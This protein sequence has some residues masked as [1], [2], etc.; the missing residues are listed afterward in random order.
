MADIDPEQLKRTLEDVL[1]STTSNSAPPSG[2]TPGI[3]DTASVTNLLGSIVTVLNQILQKIGGNAA[4]IPNLNV[5]DLTTIPIALMGLKDA[6]TAAAGAIQGLASKVPLIGG[7]LGK[8]VTNF[9]QVLDENF[10]AGQQGIGQGNYFEALG[11]AQQAGFNNLA[12]QLKYLN[13]N[14]NNGVRVIGKTADESNQR[15][16][17]LQT[18]TINTAQG[19][20]LINNG[21]I[22]ARQ[23]AEIAGLTAAS[24]RELMKSDASRQALAED[25]AKLASQMQ[26]TADITGV[27]I[28]EQIKTLQEIK[29]TSYQQLAEQVL[30]NDL[31]RQGLTATQRQFGSQGKD[32]QTLI[33]TIYAG[34]RLTRDQQRLLTQAT[35][36]RGGELIALV[37]EARRTSGLADTDPAKIAARQALDTFMAGMAKY[38]SSPEFA[39]R[40]LQTSDPALRSTLERIYADNKERGAI[41]AK[42]RESGLTAEEARK[43][44]YEGQGLARQ[45]GERQEGDLGQAPIKNYAQEFFKGFYE[46]SEGARKNVGALAGELGNLTNVLERTKNASAAIRGTGELIGGPAGRTQEE[47][48]D[49]AKETV[50]NIAGTLLGTK[51]AEAKPTETPITRD[52]LGRPVFNTPEVSIQNPSNVVINS[53]PTTKPET[54]AATPATPAPTGPDTRLRARGTLG[55]TGF[56]TELTDG[57]RY[58]HKGETTATPEQ[59][60]NLMQNSKTN[61]I[62]E[63]LSGLKSSTEG[64]TADTTGIN[65]NSIFEKF[66][67]TISSVLSTAGKIPEKTVEPVETRSTLTV[68]D[69]QKLVPKTEAPSIPSIEDIQKLVPKV[70]MP[71]LPSIEDIQ[72][73]I[74]KVE[75]KDDIKQDMP[76]KINE[77]ISNFKESFSNFKPEINLANLSQ[78]KDFAIPNITSEFSDF[79]KAPEFEMPKEPT[80]EKEETSEMFEPVDSVS[81]KDL[82]EALIQLNTGVRQ[83]VAKS[84]ESV[85]LT[86]RHLDATKKLSGNRFA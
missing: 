74:P 55:E 59:L 20:S 29:N 65:L 13:E 2:A 50:G 58:T 3:S 40:A 12:D 43:S 45:R 15:L 9:G 31:E 35:G 75:I 76:L 28:Q 67:A 18:R 52:S 71:N 49:W 54:P 37:R 14:Y 27:S 6:S 21:L 73:L 60:A 48:K 16:S 10:K 46:T 61:A 51:A 11:R 23:L 41:E 36:G 68:T 42:M 70:E 79:F 34:G 53:T 80:E 4:N 25:T 44:L 39:Q 56:P 85:T 81:I 84:T 47:A 78:A 69:I 83:L 38:Q 22:S 86:E 7:T 17:D 64:K 63:M 62:N 72:K 33:S 24:N 1:R 8:F 66:N 82:H 19:Q 5:T 30:A 77:M 57:W 26:A 32:M